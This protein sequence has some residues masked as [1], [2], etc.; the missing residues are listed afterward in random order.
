MLHVSDNIIGME[1]EPGSNRN[2]L[3]YSVLRIR[4]K[5]REHQPSHR[6]GY[7]VVIRTNL[8]QG[9]RIRRQIIDLVEKGQSYS[10]DYFDIPT[11]YDAIKDDYFVDVLLSEVGFFEYKARAESTRRDQPWSKWAD[12]PNIGISVTP[13]AYGK[14]NSIY[15]AFI[16]QFS[17]EKDHASLI[18]PLLEDSI[19]RLEEHG[20][21][22][23]P[24]GG[25]FEQF[26]ECLP[27][28]I[29]KLGMKIIHL[30][31]INP[32]PT[33][34]GRMGMY[35]SPYATTDYFG[36]DPTYGT[37]SR[38]KTIEDQFIDVTSTIHGMGAKVFLDMVINHTGWPSSLLFTHRKWFKTREDKMLVSPGAW[39]VVWG[40]LVELDYKYKDLWQYMAN[41]FLA[42][43][44]RGI[45]GF[46]LDA[47]Y[48]IPLQV[49]QYIISKVRQEFPNAMFLL[50]GLGGPW[51][52]TEQLLTEGQM[53]WAYSELFQNYSQRELMDYLS[54]AQH[55]SRGKGALVH[56]AETHDN[57]R[58]AK[59]GD[60]YALMRLHL[61][62]FTSFTGS[63]GF[64]NGVEW[65]A[66]EKIDVH[67]NSGLNW[68][69]PD[70]LVEEI[71]QINRIIDE[72]PAFWMNDNLEIIKTDNQD[73]LAFIRRN[74]DQ[75]NVLLCLI[76]LNTAESRGVELALDKFGFQTLYHGPVKLHDLLE[77]SEYIMAESM[78]VTEKLD[79]G[80]CVLYRLEGQNTPSVATVPALYDCDFNAIALIYQI[81]LSRFSPHE[82]GGIDQEKLLREVKDFRRFIALVN[83]VSLEFLTHNDIGKAMAKVDADLIDRYSAVWTFRESSKE[84][85]L[86][87]DKWLVT[88]T[89]TPCTAYLKERTRSNRA[90]SIQRHDGLG[91]ETFFAPQS[92]NQ[93]LELSFSWM[94]MR[95][96]MMQREK[97]EDAYP[98]LSVP[99][100]KKIVRG[101][102]VYPIK[103]AKRQLQANYPTVLLTN[104]LGAHCQAS[105]MPGKVTSKYDALLVTSLDK[106]D[107]TNRTA[108]VKT[109]LESVQLG[110]KYFSL[111]ES[112]LVNFTRYPHPV[113]EF[114]YDDGEYYARIER[115]LIMAWGEETVYVRYKVREANTPVILTS[116]CCLEYRN[117]HEQVRLD[118][119]PEREKQMAEAC[120]KLSGL[121]GVIFRPTAGVEVTLAARNGE[122]ID[123]PHWLRNIDFPQDRDY[124]LDDKG[125]MFAPGVFQFELS[126][127]VAGAVVMTLGGKEAVSRSSSQTEMSVNKRNKAM[128]SWVPVRPAQKDS[129]VRMLV[130][131]LDQFIIRSDDKWLVLAGYPWLGMRSWDSLLCVEGILEAGREEVVADVIQ[132]ASG[133]ED[134]GLLADW[135]VGGPKERT[136]IEASLRLF[137]AAR[138][139]VTQT[140][141]AEFWDEPVDKKRSLR[142][143]LRGIYDH[144]KHQVD[145]R[146]YLDVESGMLFC[147][148][149]FSWMNTNIPRATP[150]QGYPI[151]VQALWYDALEIVGRIVP[152]YAGE[153]GELRAKIKDNFM[154]YYWDASREF[155]ADTLLTR[156]Q[157]GASE[158]VA[159]PALRVNQLQAIQSGLVPMEQARQ[160]ID[161]VTQRLLI[162][163]GVRTLSEDTLR[164]PLIIVDERG[165]LL[166]DPKLPYQGRYLGPEQQRRVA[167]HNGTAWSHWYPSFI[168]SRAAVF[169]FSD[170]AAKQ[171]LAFFEPVWSEMSRG[172][173]GSIPEIRDGDTPHHPR[174]CYAY[175]PA[176]AESLRVYMKL[177]YRRKL[178]SSRVKNNAA[179]EPDA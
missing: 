176:I 99:S 56:Y 160:V 85:I 172:G 177:K 165:Q 168:E 178:Q 84:F 44:E 110:Q 134:D 145:G 142:D 108:L 78:H 1:C 179:I 97:H 48:M 29:E 72:N 130:S 7:R 53:N 11:R 32:V 94:I 17:G 19:K 144:L 8:N 136:S 40:D 174:G 102:K 129:L 156:H 62:A 47:G 66:T 171:A 65:L 68:G 46:R 42:W 119:Q 135:L 55:V 83:T 167:Y 159:D 149:G 12:G 69:N 63:W 162:P 2:M 6:D 73:I 157:G 81:L 67:R 166:T 118:R 122:Y 27:F 114:H 151:E 95:G 117:I 104:G 98:V 30:L 158:G 103:L 139:Y 88:Y 121:P 57:D 70:N 39:G 153:V 123:Q 64:T 76:N 124:G 18:K 58:L 71:A 106:A 43:C 22:V 38:Y 120:R 9:D 25:N 24:P 4:V 163:A 21:C 96:K 131:G 141:R 161:R 175:A 77:D 28:I 107:P 113:W 52:T 74:A 20:A 49:W 26:K 51:E 154:S 14:N 126:R 93:H 133:T 152:D 16:R 143:V 164:I 169:H 101:R 105:A 59:K 100:G 138:C 127:S 50:E 147:P 41:V 155:L 109:L 132:L 31:P 79:P 125:D 148:A 150:R 137:M 86:S 37:F 61:C 60:I 36:I 116:K 128:L 5:V 10:T 170:L 146:P 112:F 35:G 3:Q 23:L 34:Y 91:Y 33:A 15:C 80:E 92:E 87:G 75:S 89:Y 111:D 54:Y 115:T 82:V 13:L 173:I 140:G 45:D 90:E